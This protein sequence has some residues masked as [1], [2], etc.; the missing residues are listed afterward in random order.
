MI[1]EN[2]IKPIINYHVIKL[3]PKLYISKDRVKPDQKSIYNSG[4]SEEMII[5]MIKLDNANQR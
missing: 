1:K 4:Y 5:A 3:G 2:D